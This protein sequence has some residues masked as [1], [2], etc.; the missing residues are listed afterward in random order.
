MDLV[1][2]IW[3]NKSKGEVNPLAF[4][5]VAQE[6]AKKI[7]DDGGGERGRQNKSSQIR[8]YYNVIFNLNQ[9]AQLEGANWNV[10]L[11]QLHRQLALV[12]YAK[13][14]KLVTNSFVDM[15]DELI[16]A[17]SEKEEQGRKDLEVIT[18]FL[19]AFMAYYRECRPR[20]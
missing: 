7:S 5:E 14:R 3:R 18:N 8:K 13:G 10:I 17:V 20:D 15:M 1:E 11:A 4:S 16:R 2:K 12:H 6:M 9:R 19:E